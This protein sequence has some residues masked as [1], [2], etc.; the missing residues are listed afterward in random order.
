[1]QHEDECRFFD[2][3]ILN[4]FFSRDYF[5]LPWNYNILQHWDR[6]WGSTEP[7]EGIYHYMGRTL[8]LDSQEPRDLI[9]YEAFVKT[10]WCDAGFICTYHKVIRDIIAKALEINLNFNHKATTVW[11][12]RKR[13]FVGAKTDEAK[14]REMFC[15][16]PEEPFV[17]IDEGWEKGLTLPYELGSHVYVFFINNFDKLKEK[18]DEA[19]WQEWED[20]MNGQLL[21]MPHPGRLLDEYRIFRAM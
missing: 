11:I 9:F 17:P 2:Q 6:E 13:V 16:L 14:L 20:Y 12:K 8:R 10:P 15:L 7:V 5:S 4:Y 19:G 1:M 21:I 3:E 18:L